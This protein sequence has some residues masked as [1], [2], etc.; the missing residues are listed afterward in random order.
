MYPH[1]Q[2]QEHQWQQ[3]GRYDGEAHVGPAVG[4]S[5]PHWGSGD[6]GGSG[7]AAAGVAQIWQGGPKRSLGLGVGLEG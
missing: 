7:T 3:Q 6:G 4:L 5:L 1:Q 2:S